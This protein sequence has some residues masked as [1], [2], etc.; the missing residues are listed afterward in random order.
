MT[1]EIS[2]HGRVKPI[3]G[4]L[5]KVEAA[6]QAGAKTVIIP[7]ENWQ[8]IFDNLEGLR[9]IPVDTV[10]DVFREVFDWKPEASQIEQ[11]Q[12]V[13]EEIAPPKPEVF[14]PASASFLRAESPRQGKVTDSGGC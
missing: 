7:A 6:F 10:Q 4:V 8:S 3:G 11:S 9:V 14:P 2:I 1:G 5:A 13:A 12:V